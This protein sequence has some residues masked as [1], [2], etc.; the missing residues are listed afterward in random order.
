MPILWNIQ[1]IKNCFSLTLGVKNT[2]CNFFLPLHVN[3]IGAYKHLKKKTKQ[4]L[5]V[6]ERS[7]PAEKK[8]ERV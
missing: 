4:Q 5:H 6:H 7:V 3:H 2:T 8:A 1:D